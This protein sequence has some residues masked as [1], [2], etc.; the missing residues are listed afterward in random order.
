[1]RLTEHLNSVIIENQGIVQVQ[2]A[3]EDLSRIEKL[4]QLARAS[5]DFKTMEKEALF[6]GWTKGDFRTHELS[7]PLKKLLRSVYDYEKNG[8]TGEHDDEIMK[9]WIEFHKMRL[10][11]L[12]HCL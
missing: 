9:N 12:V 6:I 8:M 5:D 1:M 11:V 10:K 4:I 2:L 3:K 7:D